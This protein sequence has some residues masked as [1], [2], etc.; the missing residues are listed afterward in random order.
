MRLNQ[1]VG[2]EVGLVVI[3]DLIAVA[4]D[5]LH[6]PRCRIRAVVVDQTIGN[7]TIDNVDQ[8]QSHVRN[9]SCDHRVATLPAMKTSA[10]HVR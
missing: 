7:S 6:R 3:D 4:A 2:L 1:E 5:D 8:Q 9:R 10:A